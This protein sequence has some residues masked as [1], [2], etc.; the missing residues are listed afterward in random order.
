ME[1]MAKQWATEMASLDSTV[2]EMAEQTKALDTYQSTIN[3]LKA[4][5]QAQMKADAEKVDKQAADLAAA[6]KQ[7]K[8]EEKKAKVA[9]EKADAAAKALKV[10][11]SHL[12]PSTD[13]PS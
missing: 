5:L 9:K 10:I 3:E 6:K 13:H 4:Q 7:L 2:A 1:T 11:L 12:T 8:A